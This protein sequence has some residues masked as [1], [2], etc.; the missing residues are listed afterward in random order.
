MSGGFVRGLVVVAAAGWLLMGSGG[1]A[2]REKAPEKPPVAEPAVKGPPPPANSPMAK[3]KPGM[4]PEEVVEILGAPSRQS[5]YPTG[6][7]FTPFYY[8][9]DRLQGGRRLPDQQPGAVP[10][11][12][13]DRAGLSVRAHPNPRVV[14]GIQPE[15]RRRTPLTGGGRSGSF[16]IGRC[17]RDVTCSVCSSP[18][19]SPRVEP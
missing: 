8:G 2:K 14:A 18:A 1:C 5:A 9:P 12:R 11:V 13:S 15:R 7:A 4:R 16:S 3:V 10:G 19:Y 17:I 6:K